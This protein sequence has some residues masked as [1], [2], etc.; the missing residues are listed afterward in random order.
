MVHRTR[1]DRKPAPRAPRASGDGPHHCG[2]FC[3]VQLCSPRERGWSGCL[4]LRRLL[5]RVLPARAGMVRPCWLPRSCTSRAPRA[6]GDGP[7]YEGGPGCGGGCAPRASGDGPPLINAFVLTQMCSPR[8]RGWSRRADSVAD[9]VAVLPARAGMVLARTSG[10]RSKEGAPRASGD[11]PKPTEQKE[12][13]QVRSDITFLTWGHTVREGGLEPPRPKTQGPK[14]CAYANFAT[15]ALFESVT[16]GVFRA[17]MAPPCPRFPPERRAQV[18]PNMRCYQRVHRS[19]HMESI[20][21]EI[22]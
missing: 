18:R 16:A 7:G 4:R 12:E 17:P 9:H 20:F 5:C 14:P 6:S 3:V 11:G 2:H 10:I 21:K 13:P 15:R 19:T 8:E 1:R 22:A